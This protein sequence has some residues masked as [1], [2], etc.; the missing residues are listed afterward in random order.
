[1]AEK[2]FFIRV[3]KM[4]EVCD[5]QLKAETGDD[6]NEMALN[7]ALKGDLD[8]H[9]QPM[10]KED[11]DYLKYLVIRPDFERQEEDGNLLQ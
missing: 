5:L 2:S 10:T 6:A 4:T 9:F 11:D 8:K 3:L 1:M 7:M